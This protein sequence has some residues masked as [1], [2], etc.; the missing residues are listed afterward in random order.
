MSYLNCFIILEHPLNISLV[1]TLIISSYTLIN[2]E[3]NVK[4]IEF[5][6]RNSIIITLSC[7]VGNLLL[8]YLLTLIPSQRLAFM[9]ELL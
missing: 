3:K 6:L 1:G 7:I 5:T 9:D 2:N 8:G 4:V